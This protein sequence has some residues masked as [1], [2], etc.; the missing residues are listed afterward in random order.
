MN[1]PLL[2]PLAIFHSK[3]SSKFSNSLSVTRSP[4]AD[5]LSKS[6]DKTPSFTV[7]A[8]GIFPLLYKCHPSVDFPSKSNTHPA[9]LSASVNRLSPVV[10]EKKNNRVTQMRAEYLRRMLCMVLLFDH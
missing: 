2:P 1:T 10:H 9:F 8:E 4:W 3:S 7:Q 5:L 6:Q